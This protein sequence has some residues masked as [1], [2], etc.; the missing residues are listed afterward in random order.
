MIA[1]EL[2]VSLHM[3]FMDARERRHE[4]I[5]VEHL[6]LALLDNPSAL[7]ELKACGADIDELRKLVG[8]QVLQNIFTYTHDEARELM[9]KVHRDGIGLCGPYG[10]DDAVGKAEQVRTYAKEHQHP[11]QRLVVRCALEVN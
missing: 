6:L 2:E 3:A 7:H 4:F 8:E 1:Q 10:M 11:L 9:L 5:T